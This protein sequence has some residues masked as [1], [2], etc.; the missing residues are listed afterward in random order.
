MLHHVR[1]NL[2]KKMPPRKGLEI[3]DEIIFK[4]TEGLVTPKYKR[5]QDL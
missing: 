1:G 5:T 4:I 2:Y 3:P